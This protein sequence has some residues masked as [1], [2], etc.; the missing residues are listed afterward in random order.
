VRALRLYGPGDLRLED[1][2]DPVPGDGDVL[3]QVEVALTDGT[4]LKAYRRGHPVL[5]GELPSPFGH[6]VC[7]LDVATGRRVVAANSAPCGACAACRRGQ[8]TL[9]ES[10]FPLLNCAYAELLLVPE[11]IAARNLLPVPPD[12]A[13]E[14]AA[15]TEPLA[16]CLHGIDVA[17]V[18]HGQTVAVVGLGAIG[19]ML[20]AC[21]ADAG[22]RPVGVG[23]R[24]ERRALAPAFAAVAA[25]PEGVDVAIE[26][27]GTV[28]A[29]ERA[30]SL[31]RP[32]GTVLA[33]GG[34]P[35]DARVAVDPYRIHNE[36]VR[37]VGSFH[38]TPRHVR[39]A[40]AFLASGA[41]PFERL[42]TH[43]VG[44]E[45]VATLFDDPPS[46]YLKAAVRP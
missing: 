9:C 22:A 19:L 2:P 39:A 14:V 10:L 37:L 12:L 35:R 11:R 45:G 20:C 46:D 27:A 1:I 23:S 7:G 38:H 26:A 5:L 16:C 41:Y 13:P 6:E 25:E 17:G 42:I 43:E 40:L 18:E 33:F 36:E 4:D 31:V 34:L 24:E 28:E 29:W 30:L 32:G 44:L 15:L 8:E 21:V 3:L